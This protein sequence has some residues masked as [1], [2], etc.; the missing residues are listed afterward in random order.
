MELEKL[1]QLAEQWIDDNHYRWSDWCA[2]IFDYA[3]TSWR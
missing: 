2:E 3:E 1:K